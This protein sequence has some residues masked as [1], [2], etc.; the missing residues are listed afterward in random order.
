MDIE[1]YFEENPDVLLIHP[2]KFSG[3]PELRE[4]LRNE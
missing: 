4:E 2:V 3:F 1:R